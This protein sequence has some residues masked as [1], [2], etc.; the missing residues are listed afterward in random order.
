MGN[1]FSLSYGRSANGALYD[2][3]NSNFAGQ[4]TRLSQTQQQPKKSNWQ[5]I[6][7][8][9]STPTNTVTIEKVIMDIEEPVDEKLDKT[10]SRFS[11]L[12][13]L[14]FFL[15][16]I[17]R[18]HNFENG[19]VEYLYQRYF[20]RL[21]QSNLNAMLGLLI[22]ICVVLIV[23]NYVL[24]N[25]PWRTSPV[26]GVTLGSFIIIYIILEILLTR[27]FVNEIHIIVFSFIILA[28]FFGIEILVSLDSQIRTATSGVWCTLFF[29][30]STYALLPLPMQETVTSGLLLSVVQLAFAIGVNYEDHFIWK[31]VRMQCFLLS[32]FILISV[33]FKVKKMPG[34]F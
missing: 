33:G 17:F 16:R 1:R 7:H 18:V 24:G 28:S 19:Q 21:N 34:E 2:E 5:V 15:R 32:C 27:S 30:Y 11:L 4:T 23:L 13:D 12:S 26:R 9:S 29:I 3:S 25:G 22:I 10:K 20:L 14:C 8:F 31:Q 6:E